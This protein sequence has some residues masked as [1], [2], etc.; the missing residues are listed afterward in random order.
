[1]IVALDHVQIA[2]PCGCEAEARA[3]YGE[4]L[5]LY[6]VPKPQK[7]AA[8]GG[9]WFRFGVQQLHIGV[10]DEFRAA[11]KA[12]P[13]FAVSNINALAQRL[14]EAGVAITWDDAIPDLRRF[15]INDPWGNRLELLE[16]AAP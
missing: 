13:A 7:L 16:S 2:A 3:F 4:L 12:H 11:R 14:E 1:V 8:R 15:Y 10:E 5:G 6:E 9:V